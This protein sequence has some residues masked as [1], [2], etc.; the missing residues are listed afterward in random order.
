MNFLYPKFPLKL[1][2]AMLGYAVLGAVLAGVY[3]ILHDQITYSIS[4]EYFTRLKFHQFHRADF[5]LP[6]RVFAGEI[7]F[8]ATWWVGFF[9]AW[10]LA[11]VGVPTLPAAAARRHILR[12]FL[13]VFACGLGGGVLG[14]ILASVRESFGDYSSWNDIGQW[15]SI[16]DLPSFVRVAYIHN[17]GYLGG[18]L[19]LVAAIVYVWRMKKV[20]QMREDA[21]GER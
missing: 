8:L 13:I 2:P 6:P 21:K 9:A 19:G 1:L 18:L 20:T 17:G 11:R 10:F 12:G 4:P 14:N 16:S 5:G 3:G 15:L 7:G